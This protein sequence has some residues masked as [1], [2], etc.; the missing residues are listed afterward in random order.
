MPVKSPGQQL[1][2]LRGAASLTQAD[3][4]DALRV[5]TRTIRRWERGEEP[6]PPSKL[7]E[8]RAV[9]D[10]DSVDDPMSLDHPQ[11]MHLLGF[12]DGLPEGVDPTEC[13]CQ[14]PEAWRHRRVE[15]FGEEWVVWDE[16][17]RNGP[18]PRRRPSKAWQEYVRAATGR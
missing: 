9:C 10:E 16:Q 14:S 6:V 15:E 5:T 11:L 4:A 13:A 2:S 12:E 1:R 7:D 17:G 3:L 8:A 18:E